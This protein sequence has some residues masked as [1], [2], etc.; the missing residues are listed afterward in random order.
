MDLLFEALRD[1]EEEVLINSAQRAFIVAM[2]KTQR[3]YAVG[4][5]VTQNPAP[6]SPLPSAQDLVRALPLGQRGAVPRAAV[7]RPVAALLDWVTNREEWL[8]TVAESLG[9]AAKPT[10]SAVPQTNNTSQQR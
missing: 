8:K 3:K 5:A 6:L 4:T 10:Y 9:A 2:P 7:E 1:F